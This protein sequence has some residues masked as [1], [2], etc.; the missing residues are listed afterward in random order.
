MDRTEEIVRA[1]DVRAVIE[2][3]YVKAALDDIES[4]LIEQLVRCPLGDLVLQNRIADLLRA[5]RKFVEV[6]LSH[7]ETGK[8][9]EASPETPPQSFLRSIMRG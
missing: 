8:L 2:N 6:L 4:A 3:K 1:N 5:K 7:I 9:A